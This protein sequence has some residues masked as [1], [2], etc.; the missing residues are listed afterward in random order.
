MKN[1]NEEKTE[2]TE[3]KEK[4]IFGMNNKMSRPAFNKNAG[5]HMA[6]RVFFY[7]AGLMILACGITMNTKTGLGVSPIISVPYSISQIW[8]FN[9]G[10]TTLLFYVLFAAAQAVLVRKITLSILLQV[11]LS[12]VFTR[13]LNLFDMILPESGDNMAE[14]L[15]MLAAA[16]LLTGLGAL[17]SVKAALVPNPGD[18]IVQEVAVAIHKSMGFAKNAFDLANLCISCAIGLVFAGQPVGIGIGTVLTM[19]FTGRAIALFSC[20]I[21]KKVLS[22]SGLSARQ[23]E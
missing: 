10:N 1:K 16:I 23:C 20:V 9:F 4:N 8:D 21:L 6:W 18:G 15:I 22:L 11:P 13:F 3:E 14:R 17:L 5:V 7:A 19:L 2:E 12:L